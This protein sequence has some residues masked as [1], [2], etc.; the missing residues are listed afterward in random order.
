MLW[1]RPALSRIHLIEEKAMVCG[2]DSAGAGVYLQSD[3]IPKR[4]TSERAKRNGT[5]IPVKQ[6][7]S[8]SKG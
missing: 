7:I 3:H 8:K 4:T 2:A 6:N 5:E 1:G